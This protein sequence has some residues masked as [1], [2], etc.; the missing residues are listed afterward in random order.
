M[1]TQNIRNTTRAESSA[2]DSD[3]DDIESANLPVVAPNAR[4]ERSYSPYR[5]SAPVVDVGTAD[6]NEDVSYFFYELKL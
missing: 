5:D 4:A 1:K 2:E 6:S 3:S